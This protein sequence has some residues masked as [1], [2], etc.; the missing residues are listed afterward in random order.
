MA[1]LR[2]WRKVK[3]QVFVTD[4]WNDQLECDQ[5]DGALAQVGGHGAWD[6][7]Q[8]M[9]VNKRGL[10]LKPIQENKRG[11]REVQFFKTVASSTDPAVKVFVD[12]IPQFHGVSKKTKDDG[13][14]KE[15]LVMENLT[16]NFSKACIMDIK[17]GTR[18]WGPDASPEKIAQ[19]D[20]SYRGTK[21]PFGFSVPGLSAYRGGDKEEVVV[22]SKE[23]GK[24]LTEENIDQVLEIFLDISTDKD[25]A[26]Q[27]AQLFIGELKKIEQLFLTQTTY[28]FYA[29]SLLFVYDAEGAKNN[30]SLGS[31]HLK[32]F[33]NVKMIDFAHVWPAEEGKIDQNYLKGVQSLI[34][35]FSNV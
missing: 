26:R 29:S 1:N 10:V 35:L 18:T 12:F 13:K 14:V 24:T 17:I 27:L 16:G 6:K 7:D 8:A 22:K 30:K 19:Q 11:E 33:L 32:E 25:L 3:L 28:N 2:P 21:I 31:E 5:P 4:K 15:F 34:K 20:A 23:F 9:Q